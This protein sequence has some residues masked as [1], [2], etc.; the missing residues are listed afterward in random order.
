MAVIVYG[1]HVFTKLTGYFGQREEATRI[2]SPVDI[3][4]TQNS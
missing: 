4:F 3:S 2:S 1:T